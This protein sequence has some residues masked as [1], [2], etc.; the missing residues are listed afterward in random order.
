M[1][2]RLLRC[3]RFNTAVLSATSRGS[4]RLTCENKTQRC[5]SVTIVSHPPADFS[6]T[7]EKILPS[8]ATRLPAPLVRARAFASR[9]LIASSHALPLRVSS[10][11]LH[12]DDHA[13]DYSRNWPRLHSRKYSRFAASAASAHP[14]PGLRVDPMIVGQAVTWLRDRE[15]DVARSGRVVEERHRGGHARLEHVVAHGKVEST[16]ALAT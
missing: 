11:S 1:N 15:A 16:A 4:L 6:R 5:A 9:G 7:G 8:S 12:A 13:P 14:W 2:P 3:E 10:A